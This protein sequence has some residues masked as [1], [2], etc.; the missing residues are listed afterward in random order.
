M[1]SDGRRVRARPH[2]PSASL[3]WFPCRPPSVVRHHR[4]A[5]AHLP[6]R[7]QRMSRIAAPRDASTR[8]RLRP[9]QR[10][11]AVAVPAHV[12]R[13]E[14]PSR[15]RVPAVGDEAHARGDV[16]ETA[17]RARRSRGPRPGWTPP[18]Q[19]PSALSTS[20]PS[21]TP[22]RP[23]PQGAPLRPALAAPGA[24]RA[25]D[26]RGRHLA[27]NDGRGDRGVE[28]RARREDR[29]AGQRARVARLAQPPTRLRRSASAHRPSAT[30]TCE[31]MPWCSRR[32][33]CA[34]KGPCCS[35][36]SRPLP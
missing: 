18:R 2:E 32:S 36:R 30:T 14:R 35:W 11:A 1:T 21:S 5:F 9:R 25:R 20:S 19:H 28:R 26:P 33:P 7:G 3:R 24:G 31:E 29:S 12:R 6:I 13:H 4:C 34:R 17:S 16:P 27:P 15:G 10:R 8:P 22:G 23:P